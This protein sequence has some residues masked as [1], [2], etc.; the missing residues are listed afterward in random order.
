MPTLTEISKYQHIK[1]SAAKTKQNIS[2]QNKKKYQLQ[3]QNKISAGQ[4]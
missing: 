2:C 3:K 4:F 1:I